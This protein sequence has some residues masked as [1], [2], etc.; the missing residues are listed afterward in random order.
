MPRT[1][2]P[3]PAHPDRWRSHEKGNGGEGR[4]RRCGVHRARCGGITSND[5]PGCRLCSWSMTVHGPDAA[6]PSAPVEGAD[7]SPRV[8]DPVL[9]RTFVA[10][11]EAGTVTELAVGAPGTTLIDV[12]VPFLTVLG[13][14]DPA[15]RVAETQL[16]DSLLQSV[17]QHDLVVLPST[18]PAPGTS[19]RRTRAGWPR[20]WRPTAPRWRWSPRTPPS[21]CG[22]CGSAPGRRRSGSTCTRCGVT[23]TSPRTRLR[24][25]PTG[26]GP[27]SGSATRRTATPAPRAA[28]PASSVR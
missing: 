28:G 25:W 6:S 27:S 3:A 19:W 2:W 10:V 16:D 11:A 7:P 23:T 5:E 20:P 12:V 13:P 8:L 22:P 17:A 9:L 14:E 18:P 15:V 4:G 26:C 21:G 1:G 24:P